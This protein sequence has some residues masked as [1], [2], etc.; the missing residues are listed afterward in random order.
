MRGQESGGAV[1]GRL[2]AQLG[3]LEWGAQR[4]EARRR[5]G[6]RESVVP[7]GGKPGEGKPG[8][9]EASE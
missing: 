2:S 1:C 8:E 6:D 3:D 9:W 7:V 5:I 4:V